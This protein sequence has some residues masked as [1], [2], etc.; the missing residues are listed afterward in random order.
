MNSI[1]SDSSR[2]HGLQPTRLLGPWDFPGKSTGVECH[3]LLRGSVLTPCKCR[4]AYVCSVV[5]NSLQ[6]H[7]HRIFQAR[8][9][10]W[11]LLHFLLQEIFPT[12][13]LNLWL[14]HW[15]AV[16]FVFVFSHCPTWQAPNAEIEVCNED[17]DYQ[18]KKLNL[19]RKDR[20]NFTKRV[21]FWV[22]IGRANCA[23]S[24]TWMMILM[25][26]LKWIYF[27]NHRNVQILWN[28]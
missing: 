2:P 18:G 11:V 24:G 20:K 14:Q 28:C 6:P 23:L 8:I 13:G 7:G 27:N 16:V 15:Q 19:N 9:L 1:V 3:C 4:V 17:S 12:K 10:V 25:T 21:K 22:N 26:H 5:S